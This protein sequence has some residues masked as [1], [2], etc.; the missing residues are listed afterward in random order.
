MGIRAQGLHSLKDTVPNK[1]QYFLQAMQMAK[2]YK[3]VPDDYAFA[4][5]NVCQLSMTQQ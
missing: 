2:P 3:G 4:D 1:M 5:S